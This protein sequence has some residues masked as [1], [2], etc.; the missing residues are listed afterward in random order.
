MISLKKP[1][2]F[3]WDEGNLDKNS[4]KHK[5]NN[6]EA[7]EVFF[8]NDKQEYPDPNHSKTEARKIIV[9]RTKNGRHLFIVYTKRK[10]KIRVISARDL[11]KRKERSLYEEAA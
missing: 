1:V 11:N 10:N 7:E 4:E 6:L 8:D 5:V 2:E 3:E 9:G